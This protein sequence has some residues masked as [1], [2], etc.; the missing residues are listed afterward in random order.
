MTTEISRVSAFV[1]PELGLEFVDRREADLVTINAAT[2]LFGQHLVIEW[3]EPMGDD[4]PPG[5]CSE[6]VER[7]NEIGRRFDEW[8]AETGSDAFEAFSQTGGTV[9]RQVD[10]DPR[11]AGVSLVALNASTGDPVGTLGL[12]NVTPDRR[13]AYLIPGLGEIAGRPRESVWARVALYLLEEALELS[14]GDSLDLQ[15]ILLPD[16]T[17][18]VS[19]SRDDSRGMAI[20]FDELEAAGAEFVESTTRPGAVVRIELP[21]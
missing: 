17:P 18:E 4:A 5:L 2:L 19:F 16:E 15:A 21:A 13:A 6:D 3:R 12:H 9:V 8:Q 20:Y 14:D 10:K 11:L 1:I 7:A